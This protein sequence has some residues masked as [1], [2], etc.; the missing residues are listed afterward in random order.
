MLSQEPASLSLLN[1]KYQPMSTF[2]QL[3]TKEKH[4]IIY[5][6][7][8]E[9]YGQVKILQLKDID[10]KKWDSLLNSEN[11][12]VF[13]AL[14]WGQVWN[15]SYKN[16]H[17]FFLVIKTDDELQSAI[18]LIEIQKFGFKSYYSMPYG[19]YGAI[20]LNPN[21][22]SS[23]NLQSA[24]CDLQ[25]AFAE[26]AH[27]NWGM[28]SFSDFHEQAKDLELLGFKKLNSVTYVLSLSKDSQTLWSQSITST[29]RQFVRQA[30]RKGV[31]ISLVENESQVRECY[32]MLEE[33]AKRHN[34]KSPRFS[35]DF[36][37]NIFHT[38]RKFLRWTIAIQSEQPLANIINFVYKD[39]ITYWDG[40]SYAY[41]LQSRPNDILIWD[42]IKWGCENDYKYYD[43]RGSPTPGLAQFK[44][45]W[46]A[47]E[48]HYPFYYKKS[49]LFK[50]LKALNRKI[51]HGI[52]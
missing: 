52:F 21:L 11:A 22:S 36:Y 28:L 26:L 43:L 30:Q 45:E 9:S 3:D 35:L 29:R 42:A 46:G 51:L 19:D 49:F 41:A 5:K 6:M 37:L 33:T 2:L 7:S 24:I 18:L 12:S 44:Q 4:N 15:L 32:K 40:G 16:A 50:T 17:P 8:E 34:E 1:K 14:E 10:P 47:E 38:M 48:K 39:T 25:S 13:N 31:K 27:G 20:L 23:C